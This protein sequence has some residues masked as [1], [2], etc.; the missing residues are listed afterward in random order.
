GAGRRALRNPASGCAAGAGEK[1]GNHSAASPARPLPRGRLD[2]ENTHH[3][4]GLPRRAPRCRRLRLCPRPIGYTHPE[5]P[6]VAVVPSGEG[7][8]R[9]LP[10]GEI[11]IPFGVVTAEQARVGGA[12][13][14]DLVVPFGNGQDGTKLLVDLLTLARRRGAVYVSDVH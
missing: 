4:P 14:A 13:P 8:R 9:G 6:G 5:A 10:A 11:S 1:E 7:E 2:D 12:R 3:D